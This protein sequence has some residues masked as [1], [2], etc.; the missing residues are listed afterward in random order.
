[1][2]KNGEDVQ[3]EVEE[4]D[5]NFSFVSQKSGLALVGACQ[6]KIRDSMRK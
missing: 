5:A 3:E 1:M 4:K 6:I 2:D